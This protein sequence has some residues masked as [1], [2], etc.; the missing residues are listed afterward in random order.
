VWQV[1]ALE[2]FPTTKQLCFKACAGPGKTAVLAW[3]G[4]NFL[5]T[6]RN[7]MIGATSISGDNLRANLWTE[8]ARWRAKSTLLERQF[9]QT[10]KTV[11]ARAFPETWKLEARTW[12]KDADPT[13]I[14]NALAGVHAEYVMWL[15]DESGD[16]PNAIMPVMQAIFAG[17]PK[18][19]HIVI[20]GN[21]TRLDGPLYKACTSA[22]RLWEVV[23]ITADPDDPKRTP[24]VSVEH[25]RAQIE[26][27]GR[28]NPW[29]LVRIFG[30][31]PSS[32]MNALIGPEEVS[33]AMKRHWR[34]HE[35]GDA[36][37]ILG[38]DVAREGDDASVIARR[39]GLQIFP[40]K[41][42][43]N[44]LSVQGGGVVKRA[45]DDWGADACFIDMTGGWGAGWY[46]QVVALG[47]GPIPVYFSGEAHQKNRYFNKRAEMAWEFCQWIK[48]GGALPDSRELLAALTTTTY[49]FKGDK[50]L[51]EDKK[52]VKLRL[53]YSPD[54]M[55]ACMMTFAEPVTAREQLRVRQEAQS[56][57]S[58]YK[59][60][61]EIDRRGVPVGGAEYYNPFR[62]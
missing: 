60:H 42:M 13:Q 32:S 22:R 23:E 16:Y 62:D 46:D 34:P 7:P 10:G 19:A 59:P 49:T 40:L 11:F 35:I 20:A 27:W 17:N 36:A 24:R 38:V 52:Q 44:V 15:G 26:E 3:L 31:F 33:A 30:Q 39:Q 9:E 51:L 2:K 56:V 1:E 14:G 41:R 48:R 53:G 12:A 50:I 43:R 28:D 5:L 47:G 21:P 25:A 8:L 55:D 45:I 58:D 61:A 18:E 37:K 4:W 29:V 57:V 54:D 6:R